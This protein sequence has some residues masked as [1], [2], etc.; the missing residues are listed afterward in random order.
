MELLGKTIGNYCHSNHIIS[1]SSTIDWSLIRLGISM[2][3]CIRTIH[4]RGIIHRDI[5]PENF[6]MSSGKI[7]LI[8]FI[9]LCEKVTGK[10]AII[11]KKPVPIGDV[12]ITYANIDKA[13]QTISYEPTHSVKDGLVELISNLSN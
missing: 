4:E 10:S 5:K 7:K 8:D 2:L 13:R 1:F 9:H 3:H 12:P 11:H 6:L